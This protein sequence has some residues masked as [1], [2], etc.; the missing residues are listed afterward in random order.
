MNNKNFVKQ[1]NLLK[2]EICFSFFI[3]LLDLLFIVWICKFAPKTHSKPIYLTEK[4]WLSATVSSQLLNY[5]ILFFSAIYAHFNPLILLNRNLQ[6]KIFKYFKYTGFIN[7]II[8]S[9]VF[10]IDLIQ[11]IF[12][13]AGC[14]FTN[15]EADD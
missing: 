7:I 10:F 8:H 6:K 11:Y 4:V 13:I 9:S 14:K 2:K 15:Q 3:L 5:S 12:V 1:K